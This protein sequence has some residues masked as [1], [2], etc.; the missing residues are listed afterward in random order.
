[1]IPS[2]YWVADK[3]GIWIY[4]E[5]HEIPI[6]LSALLLSPSP[7]FANDYLYFGCRVE[8]TNKRTALP[9][10]KVISDRVVVDS[11]MFKVDLTDNK[12]RNHRGEDWT[13]IQ[14]KGDSRVQDT[15]ITRKGLSGRLKAL[16]PLSP[17]GRF[18][19][20]NW[21]KNTTEYQV[22]K[23]EGKCLPT[24][25]SNWKEFAIDPYN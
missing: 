16:M 5:C 8:A 21:F 20:E 18:T 17:P 24:N 23:G 12:M 25:L 22:I 10:G 2:T 19:I 7:T 4:G 3:S 6:L 14:I 15:K 13:D 11:V 1:M 9:S